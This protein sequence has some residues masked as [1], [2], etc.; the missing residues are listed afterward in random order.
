MRSSTRAL[1]ALNLLYCTWALFEP[2]LPG[3]KMFD[4]AE[5]LAYRLHDRDG[6]EVRVTD[7]LP[8]GAYLLEHDDV[9]EV[10]TWICEHERERAPFRYVEP[11]RGIDV[12]L[13]PERCEVPR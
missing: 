13:G 2:R 7:S 9:A 1:I 12:M 3:W 8:R 11:T 6:V 5:P 4:S 10:V